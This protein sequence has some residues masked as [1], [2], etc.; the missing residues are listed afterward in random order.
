MN[1][2]R[3]HMSSLYSIYGF[4]NILKSS[5]LQAL[6]EFMSVFAV[7]ERQLVN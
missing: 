1:M 4:V 3:I 2:H 5:S 7:P 6:R